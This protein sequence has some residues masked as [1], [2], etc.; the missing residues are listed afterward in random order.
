MIENQEH[1]AAGFT[2]NQ[3]VYVTQMS[4]IHQRYAQDQ[5]SAIRA[6]A[7]QAAGGATR[8]TS[9]TVGGINRGALIE[10]RA[11]KAMLEGSIASAGQLRDSALQAAR[12][13][14]S[15]AIVHQITRAAARQ[16]EQGLTLRY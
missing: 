5:I 15:S 14:M 9:I 13:H 12:L 11:N 7:D 6:G 10:M 4:S 3:D 16:I 1:A 2:G 8:G